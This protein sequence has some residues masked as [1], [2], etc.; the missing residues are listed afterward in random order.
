MRAD[1][2]CAFQMYGPPAEYKR[3]KLTQHT[4]HREQV[5]EELHDKIKSQ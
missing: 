4:V 5:S 3:G 1:I 2:V